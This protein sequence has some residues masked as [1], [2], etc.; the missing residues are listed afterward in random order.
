MPMPSRPSRLVLMLLSALTLASCK[1]PPVVVP[2]ETHLIP[3]LP[4]SLQAPPESLNALESLH[5][6][7]ERLAN[8]LC[9]MPSD[10]RNARTSTALSEPS[11]PAD[12]F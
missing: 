10:S 9:A 8:E 11:A 6:L 12:I 5:L 4:P 1:T 2:V 7:L 3:D